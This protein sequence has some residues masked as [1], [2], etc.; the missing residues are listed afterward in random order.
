[1]SEEKQTYTE[2]AKS[3]RIKKVLQDSEYYAASVRELGARTRGKLLFNP[4]DD[5]ELN[6]IF[7]QNAEHFIFCIKRAVVELVTTW[8]DE[9]RAK[10]LLPNL[11]IVLTDANRIKLNKLNSNYENIPVIFECQVIGVFKEETYIKSGVAYCTECDKTEKLISL[12]KI[13]NCPNKDCGRRGKEMEI[14]RKRTF[15]GDIRTI[16]IEEPMEESASGSPR[17][18]ECEIKDESVSQTFLGDRKKIVGVFRSHSIKNSM[19]NHPVVHALSVQDLEEKAVTM[20]TPEQEKKFLALSK[21]PDWLDYLT[22]S[23]APE[24]KFEKLAKLAIILA[25]IS[26][27]KKDSLRELVHCLLIGDPSTGKSRILEYILKVINRSAMAVGGT[28]S[29]AGVTVTM[30]MMPNRQKMPRSGVIPKCHNSVAVLDEINQLEPEE[31]GKIY[32][33]MEQGHINYNKGGFDLDLKTETILCAGANPKGYSYDT[34]FGMMENIKL[35]APLVSRF[36]LVVNMTRGK[37]LATEQQVIEHIEKIRKM[38]LSKYVESE[39]L[40]TAEEMKIL[41]NFAKSQKPAMTDSASKLLREFQMMMLEFEVNNEQARGSKPIDRR[42]FES[43]YRVATSIAKIHFSKDV[44]TEHAMLAIEI[45]KQTMQSFGLKTDKGL[46]Q[47]NM[48]DAVQDKDSAAEFCWKK[49]EKLRDAK[50]IDAVEFL[51]K[52]PK[53]SPGYFKSVA[54]AEKWFDMKFKKGDIEKREGL[55][56]LVK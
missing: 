40:I 27:P 2:S 32:E 26:G 56:R 39:G 21:K 42:F 3:D 37:L 48:A 51:Q 50:F 43:M 16:M 12:G 34:D 15:F 33:A 24:I 44:T 31:L 1:M 55:Y 18:L 52:L 49:I 20:P 41:L 53:E 45:Y 22:Q 19:R 4:L 35:P 25:I 29:G 54:D 6:D 5:D 11:E 13:P 46:T 8:F 28:M 7:L 36:D 38:G 47:L 14:D 30:E 17:V 9:G 10:A 23:F